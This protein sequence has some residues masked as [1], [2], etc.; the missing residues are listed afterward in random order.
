MNKFKPE[1][2]RSQ[3]GDWVN[4]PL[5]KEFNKK[6]MRYLQ[7]FVRK[8]RKK[9]TVYP[10]KEDVFR[11]FRLCSPSDLKCVILG[12]SPYHTGEADGLAFS[13]GGDYQNISPSLQNIFKEV[14]NDVGFKDV[15]PD[16]DL[17]RWAEQGVLLLN[18]SLTVRE[19][20]AD[21]HLKIDGKKL[22][23]R[24][25]KKALRI[26]SAITKPVVFMLWG[27]HA[28]SFIK[29]TPPTI[30]PLKV[31]GFMDEDESGENKILQAYHPAAELYRNYDKIAW[32]GCSH[33]SK[34]N[35]F[36]KS[37]GI[38]TIEWQ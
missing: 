1:Q 29:D 28:K 15:A 13:N 36:L 34:A 26:C 12:Q 21:S 19:G 20:D 35:K 3:I 24:F 31:K 30:D 38:E 25:T 23:Q 22:W 4:L 2:L 10:D 8:E 6:Y 17:S 32:F 11:A 9:Y 27:S 5:W 7:K 37:K 14:E 16:P 33:F 18:T